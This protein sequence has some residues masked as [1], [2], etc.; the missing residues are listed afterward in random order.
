MRAGAH[1]PNAFHIKDMISTLLQSSYQRLDAK[2]ALI[3]ITHVAYLH[4]CKEYIISKKKLSRN[5]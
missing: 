1:I 5:I 2:N 3:G 4:K